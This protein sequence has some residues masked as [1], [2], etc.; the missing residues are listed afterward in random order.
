M[1]IK[2]TDNMLTINLVKRILDWAV[3]EFTALSGRSGHNSDLKIGEAAYGDEH[4]Y[5]K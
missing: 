1:I 5:P 4:Y 3:M 2:N